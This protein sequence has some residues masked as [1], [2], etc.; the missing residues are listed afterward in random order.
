MIETATAAKRPVQRPTVH[1]SQGLV[2]SSGTFS[3]R[4]GYHKHHKIATW[5]METDSI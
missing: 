2:A 5:G 4:L 3:A 1:V